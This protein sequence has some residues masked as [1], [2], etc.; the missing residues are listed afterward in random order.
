[1]ALLKFGTFRGLGTTHSASDD[2]DPNTAT[3]SFHGATYTSAYLSFVGVETAT[4]QRQPLDTPT[5]AEQQLWVTATPAGSIPFIDFGG[6]AEIV[7]ASYD[8]AVLSGLTVTAI[9]QR[10]AAGTG[11]VARNIEAVAGLFT[12]Q[13]CRMTGDQPATVCSAFTS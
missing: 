8:P 4:N 12:A 13:L 2:T 7:G 11:P 10:I 6:Q 1:M 5:A 3:F 9:A